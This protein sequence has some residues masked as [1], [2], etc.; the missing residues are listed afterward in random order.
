MTR[1]APKPTGYTRRAAESS[2]PDATAT[3]RWRTGRNGLL[4]C[5]VGRLHDDAVSGDS[6]VADRLSVRVEWRRGTLGALRTAPLGQG[7]EPTTEVLSGRAQTSVG[8]AGCTISIALCRGQ[9]VV[10]ASLALVQRDG[11]D[12]LVL[13]DL[14]VRL[15]LRGGT[16]VLEKA[17]AASFAEALGRILEASR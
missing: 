9:S 6:G 10:E 3:L 2:P 1:M 8:D 16:Y 11:A 4:A 5:T 12:P 15:G 13:T 17:S 14:P 7:S